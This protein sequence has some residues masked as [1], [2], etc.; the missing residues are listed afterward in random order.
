MEGPAKFEWHARRRNYELER[1]KFQIQ[2]EVTE[3]HPLREITVTIAESKGKK[4]TGS[5]A[6]TSKSAS[7][8]DPLSRTFDGPDPLSMF[9]AEVVSSSKPSIQ[10]K[11]SAVDKIVKTGSPDDAVEPWSARRSDILNRYT[12]VEKLSIV[13]ILAPSSASEKKDGSGGAVSEKVKNRLEQLDDLEEGS[14]QE[15]LSLTQQEYIKRIE[16]CVK[17]FHWKIILHWYQMVAVI[18]RFCCCK[19]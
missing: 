10:T 15:T 14:I 12:T 5:S 19:H 7:V 18:Q 8:T 11:S 16:V 1:R 17:F 3:Q 9:A 13:M 6:S 4:Q 2:A